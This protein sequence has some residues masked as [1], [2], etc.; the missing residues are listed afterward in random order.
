VARA[1][2]DAPPGQFTWKSGTEELALSL[3]MDQRNYVIKRMLSGMRSI[4]QARELPP[5]PRGAVRG[6]PADEAALKEY[7]PEEQQAV[8][9]KWA[10]EIPKHD[11][12]VVDQLEAAIKSL[13]SG[14]P[15]MDVC[16]T[17][18]QGLPQLPKTDEGAASAEDKATT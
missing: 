7:L 18:I 1:Q 14:S 8:E 15:G 4:V 11:E 9:K 6:N 3:P 12:L 2:T 16:S 10:Q 17:E 13:E 5:S